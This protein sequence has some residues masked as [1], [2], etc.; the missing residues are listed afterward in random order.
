MEP[1][2]EPDLPARFDGK[3]LIDQI[4][5]IGL[6]MGFNRVRID[7]G[8]KPTDHEKYYEVGYGPMNIV[9]LTTSMGG[10]YRVTDHT[11]SGFSRATVREV[12]QRLWDG[13]TA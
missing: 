3:W 6:K 4:H 8:A 10:L 1:F 13:V 9:T 2:R 12:L 5:L 11:W 7:R